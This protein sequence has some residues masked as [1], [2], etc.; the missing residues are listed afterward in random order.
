MEGECR[1]LVELALD[2]DEPVQ[3]LDRSVDAAE[4]QSGAFA[5]LFR[6]EERVESSRLRAFVHSDAGISHPENDVPSWR[7][8]HWGQVRNLVWQNLDVLRFDE[9]PAAAGHAITGI[10]GEVEQNLFKLHRIDL[11]WI[12]ICGQPGFDGDVYPDDSLQELL[13]FL[14]HGIQVKDGQLQELSSAESEET[15]DKRGCL[16][17]GLLDFPEIAP[18]RLV[19]AD[20]LENH[21]AIPLNRC[22]EIIEIM[23]DTARQLADGFHALRIC[24]TLLQLLALGE[25][26][27]HAEDGSHLS[28]LVAERDQPGIQP[29]FT[30]GE[31][32]WAFP[33]QR[34]PGDEDLLEAGRLS[35]DRFWRE[36]IFHRSTDELLRLNTEL[37]GSRPIDIL[38]VPAAIDDEDLIVRQLGELAI[39]LPHWRA[40]P[41]RRHRAHSSRA[42]SPV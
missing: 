39:T 19:R 11:D 8:S 12:Q 30:I 3:L 29:G 21:L 15:L 23:R 2:A 18:E 28:R 7:R 17:A 24:K 27:R 35:L 20:L 10:R 41:V 40:R 25:V 4:T 13:G 14:N 34:L 33:V 32:C 38:H 9:H 1:A 36:E 16:V 42:Q 31:G 22:K 37:F 5:D 6:S 26:P